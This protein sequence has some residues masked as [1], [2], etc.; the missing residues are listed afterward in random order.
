M[1]HHSD[2]EQLDAAAFRVSMKRSVGRTAWIGTAVGAVAAGCGFAAGLLPLAITG[3]VLFGAGL[4]NLHRPAITGMIVDGAAMIVTGIFH[5]LA[6]LW[7]EGERPSSTGKWI[8]TGAIQIVWG[9]RRLALYRV[10][11]GAVDDPQAIA[12]LESRIRELSKRNAKTDSSVVEFSTGRIRGRRNRLG[13]YPDGVIGLLEQQVV[14]LERRGDIWIETRG[15]TLGGRSV[16]VRI[17]MSDL[18]LTGRMTA[19]HFER[20]ERWKLGMSHPRPIAA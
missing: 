10:A 18:E 11:R 12:E 19:E 8:L 9:V 14:R 5:G 3:V 7:I 13:L 4:W 15:T 1:T 20:F 2:W 17:Q 6:W 16:K